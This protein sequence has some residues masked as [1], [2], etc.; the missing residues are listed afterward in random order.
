MECGVEATVG[1]NDCG[2]VLCN[3]C[4]EGVHSSYAFLKRHRRLPL[5]T[6]CGVIEPAPVEPEAAAAEMAGESPVLLAFPPSGES[7]TTP[8]VR[9]TRQNDLEPLFPNT[10]V[11][12]GAYSVALTYEH[13]GTRRTVALKDIYWESPR[14]AR[15]TLPSYNSLVGVSRDGGTG[16]RAGD[17]TLFTITVSELGSP[18]TESLQW[19]YTCMHTGDVDSTEGE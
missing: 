8:V 5:A 3:D 13:E 6:V 17:K 16:R 7:H 2:Q 18:G 11:F 15:V 10:P 19:S 14:A 12:R 1:C 9:L 4:D